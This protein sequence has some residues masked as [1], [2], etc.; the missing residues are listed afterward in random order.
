[1]ELADELDVPLVQL[2]RSNGIH[3]DRRS[4]GS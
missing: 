1:M 4:L 2:S 3:R